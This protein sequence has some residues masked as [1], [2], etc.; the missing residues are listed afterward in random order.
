MSNNL[1]PQN[2]RRPIILTGGGT[3]GH[4]L[5]NLALLSYLKGEEIHYIGSGAALEKNLIQDKI[6]YH[7]ITTCKLRRSL[8]PSN[9]L[10]PFKLLKGINDAKKLLISLNPKIIFSKGGFV[11]LPV[12]MAATKLHIPI[13]L[14]ESDITMGLANKIIAKRCRVICSTFPQISQKYKNAVHTGAILSP[15]INELKS[16][17]S[18][19]REHNKHKIWVSNQNSNKNALPNILI[20]GGSLGAAAINKVVWG[21]LPHL[22]KD[23]NIVHITGKGKSD[24]KI[25]FPN[26]QQVEFTDQIYKHLA[27]ADLV[28]SRCG[29]NSLCEIIALD[30]PAVLIPLPKKESRG[31]Q[32]DNAKFAATLGGCSIIQQENLCKE[33]LLTAIQEVKTKKWQN[34]EKLNGTERVAGIILQYAK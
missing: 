11:S 31:D 27:A 33:S 1:S 4:I 17:Y 8:A 15:E 19:Y 21:T 20:M 18:V 14:H 16:T 6:P 10:I 25:K 34:V 2:C 24:P 9:F 3:A 22:I 32:L 12:A 29:S 7:Q 28:I 26:Y 13:V 23:Y 30:K 5:P